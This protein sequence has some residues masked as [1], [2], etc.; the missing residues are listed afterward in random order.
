MK[1]DESI[2]QSKNLNNHSMGRSQHSQPKPSQSL[3]RQER[4]GDSK[5]PQ[6]LPSSVIG[7]IKVSPMLFRRGITN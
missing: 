5:A 6:L 4:E 1:Y 2:E 7:S 3:Y